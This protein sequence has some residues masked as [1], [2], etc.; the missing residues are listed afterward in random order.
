MST[1]KTRVKSASLDELTK[2]LKVLRRN[3]D[4][5]L[6]SWQSLY[7]PFYILLTEKNKKTSKKRA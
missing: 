1:L 7:S 4:R 3:I 2:E 5:D 6:K